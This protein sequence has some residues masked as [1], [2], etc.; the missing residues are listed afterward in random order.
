VRQKYHRGRMLRQIW[1]F[2]GIERQS[3]LFVIPLVDP[4]EQGRTASTLLSLIQ[5]YIWEGSVIYSDGWG[6]YRMLKD[7]GYSHYVINHSEN[8]VD[9]DNAK[10]HTQTIE[11]LWRDLKKWFKHSGMCP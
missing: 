6:A 11:Q 10:I 8:F 9:P 1:A 7:L 5:R 2:G 3:K 4:E